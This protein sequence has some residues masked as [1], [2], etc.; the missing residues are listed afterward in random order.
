MKLFVLQT[1]MFENNFALWSEEPA[2]LLLEGSEVRLNKITIILL[3]KQILFQ[4]C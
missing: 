1:H 3:L 2:D 4:I